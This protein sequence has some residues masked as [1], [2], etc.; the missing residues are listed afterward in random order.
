MASYS[1]CSSLMPSIGL[2]LGISYLPVTGLML[3]DEENQ[4]KQMIPSI[5]AVSTFLIHISYFVIDAQ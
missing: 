4:H 2:G 5:L 1:F 3:Q